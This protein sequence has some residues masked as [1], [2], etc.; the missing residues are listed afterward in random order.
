MD[1]V[2]EVED[3]L[4]EYGALL[5]EPT[6]RAFQNDDIA[7]FTRDLE[8]SF[9]SSTAEVSPNYTTISQ[10]SPA[11]LEEST[12]PSVPRRPPPPNPLPVQGEVQKR[13]TRQKVPEVL[14]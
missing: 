10:A 12:F 5:T 13:A 14:L 3:N 6:Q 7:A 11:E 8:T 9:Q 4:E 1:D 2:A